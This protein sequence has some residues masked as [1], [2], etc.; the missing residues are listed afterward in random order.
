LNCRPLPYQGSA[1]PLSYPGSNLVSHEGWWG[2]EDSN[3]RRLSHQI[4][5]LVPLATRE[6]PHYERWMVLAGGFELPT[7]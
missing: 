2:G 5:S 4:Y 3:L 7:C 6:P 1:L